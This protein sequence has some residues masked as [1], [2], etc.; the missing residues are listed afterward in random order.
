MRANL[1]GPRLDREALTAEERERFEAM[2]GSPVTVLQVGEG[3]FLR[4][5]FDWMIHE[6]RKKGLFQ[7]SVAVV[8]PRS[9]GKI[10][11]EQLIRQDGLSSVGWN[12]GILWSSEKSL[13]SFR[14]CSIL[15][16]I[17]RNF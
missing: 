2:L 3:N 13:L 10:K 6:C 9:S 16:K 4:G 14:R 15:M 5:F 8:Q 17:G 1:P 12:R 7:G 11:M